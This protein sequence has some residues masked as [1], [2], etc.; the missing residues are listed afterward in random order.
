[1]KTYMLSK[2]F[3][4]TAA[5]PVHASTKYAGKAMVHAMTRGNRIPTSVVPI[6][7]IAIGGTTMPKQNP[8]RMMTQV[9]QRN[10]SLSLVKVLG[11]DAA[12]DCLSSGYAAWREAMSYPRPLRP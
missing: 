1:L 12:I 3:W 7:L 11:N 4:T 5:N 10:E 9:V 6:A 2:R 8:P